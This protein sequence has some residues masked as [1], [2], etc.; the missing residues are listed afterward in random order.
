VETSITQA[1][2]RVLGSFV[3]S[4]IA[5][6]LMSDPWSANNPYLVSYGDSTDL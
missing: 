5:W 2:L 1:V 6:A 3:G 4:T